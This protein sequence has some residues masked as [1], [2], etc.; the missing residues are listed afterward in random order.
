MLDLLPPADAFE[1]LVLF[2][3]MTSRNDQPNRPADSL[4]RRVSEH[5]LSSRIPRRNQA[6]QVF[7]HDGVIGRFN[8]RREARAIAFGVFPSGDVARDFRDADNGGAPAADRRRGEGR[9]D[10]GAI[11]ANPYRLQV[12]NPLPG[13][14]PAAGRILFRRSIGRKDD[15]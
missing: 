7:A 14:Y 15:A 6:V 11:L 2:A 4:L 8:D 3:L 9:L 5:A 1:N 12:L 10:T 13:S